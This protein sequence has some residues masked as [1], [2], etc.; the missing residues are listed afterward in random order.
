MFTSSEKL[1]GLFI[2]NSE[3]TNTFISDNVF[4]IKHTGDRNIDIDTTSLPPLP[5]PLT[6]LAGDKIGDYIYIAGGFN[7][8]RSTKTFLRLDLNKKDKWE[9]LDAWPGMPRF[10][11]VLVAQND[12]IRACL[13]LFGGNWCW[14]GRGATCSAYRRR[15]LCY[16]RQF[17]QTDIFALS[18]DPT[19]DGFTFLD[20]CR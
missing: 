6:F 2:A 1:S 7:G 19:C 15:D 8:R 5:E 11:H 20:F 10:A 4:I 17:G 14:P 16:G 9:E 18:G 12:G 13:Y 3:R